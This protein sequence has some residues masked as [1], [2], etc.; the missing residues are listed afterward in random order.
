ML[1]GKSKAPTLG[2]A[3]GS[4]RAGSGDP[5][6]G[7]GKRPGVASGEKIRPRSHPGWHNKTNARGDLIL[8]V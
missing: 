5:M 7:G 1:S 4:R 8:R 6:G 2:L 3:A